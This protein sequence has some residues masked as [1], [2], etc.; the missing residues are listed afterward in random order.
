MRVVFVLSQDT[1][2]RLAWPTCQPVSHLSVI[3]T[4]ETWRAQFAPRERNLS[5]SRELITP[6]ILGFLRLIQR[7]CMGSQHALPTTWTTYR[8]RTASQR[9][10][11]NYKPTHLSLYIRRFLEILT[12][13]RT[14]VTHGR[15][16]LRGH[17]QQL[18]AQNCCHRP[19]V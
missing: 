3:T 16:M 19:T 6:S 11:T 5:R 8:S 15:V 13:A 17:C 4:L 12:T 18:L 1:A 7:M 9:R 14:V 2:R 10:T